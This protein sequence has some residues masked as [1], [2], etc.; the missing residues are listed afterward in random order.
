MHEEVGTFKVEGLPLDIAVDHS[1][2]P[3]DG[4]VYTA[5]F[6]ANTVLK[7]N[8]TGE[9]LATVTGTETPAGSFGFLNSNTFTFSGIAVDSSGGVNSGDLYVA[10]IEHNVV[11]RFDEAGK[12]VCQITATTPT[13]NEEQEHECNGA[14]GSATTGGGFEP[15]AVA[16][17]A[18]GDLFVADAAHKAVDEFGAKGEF[19]EEITSAAI[20]SP[21]EL[22]IAPSGVFYIVNGGNFFAGGSDV[23]KDDHGTFSVV[24]SS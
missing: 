2:G 23:V 8:S 21:A 18:V 11:D 12:F 9:P 13:S 16:I 20:T 3:G 15:T 22:A 5:M 7:L 24:D 14:P 4:D 6:P 17:N 10:D 19:I 1:G